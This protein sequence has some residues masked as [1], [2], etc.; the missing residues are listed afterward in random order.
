MKH[1]TDLEKCLYFSIA[2]DQ[3]CN[4]QNELELALF[5]QSVSEDYA[6][7][8]ELF[9]ILLFKDKTCAFNLENT[10]DCF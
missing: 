6:M 10:H 9:G 2:L 8:E 1:I 4:V 5:V 3:S 7:K